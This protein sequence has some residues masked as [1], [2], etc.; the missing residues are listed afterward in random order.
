VISVPMAKPRIWTLLQG[1]GMVLNKDQQFTWTVGQGDSKREMGGE[2]SLGG[3]NLALQPEGNNA[4]VG[5]V[6]KV[7]AREFN[8]RII[9]AP[10]GDQGLDF[11]R[12]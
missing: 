9:G 3:D 5:T 12:K 7:T 6:S 1:A 11:T 10:P 8:F 2:F 4:M